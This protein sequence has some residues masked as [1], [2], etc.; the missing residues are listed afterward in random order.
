MPTI[1]GVPYTGI[2]NINLKGV[3]S[4]KGS[5]LRFERTSSSN[6]FDS[7]SAGLYVNSSGQLIF[8]YNGTSTTLGATGVSGSI[9]S[10]DAIFQGDQ[11]LD[12]G[13]LSTLTIDRSTGNNNVLTLTNSG[14]GSGNVLQITN[15][16]SGKDINGTSNTWSVT[17]AGVAVFESATLSGA[18]G[19][20]KFTIT[21]G[22]AVLS[23]GSLTMTDADNAATLSITNNTAT[24][25]SVFVFAGSGVFTGSTT[26]SFMT[27]TPS[28]LTTG[29]AVYLPVAG[30]TTGKAVHIVGNA[31]TTGN[32]L[33]ISSSATAITGTGRML[34]LEH[35]GTTGTSATLAEITSAATD[36]TIIFKA[37]AS[38]A[39]AAGVIAKLSGSSMTTGTALQINNL[40]ALTTGIGVHIAS[41]A[42]AI[43]GAGR[44]LYVNHTGAT[45]TSA[46]L[47][48]I[49]SAANDETVIFKVT[50]SAALA[51]GKVMFLSAAAL[52]TGTVLDISGSTATTTGTLVNINDN[53]ADTGTRSLV[54]IKQDHASASGATPLTI[55]N[56]NA[57]KPLI[58]GTATAT[59]T[60][61]YKF[62]TVNGVTIWIGAGTT[63]NGNLTGTAGDICLNGGSNKPEYCTG[64]TNW[65]ALV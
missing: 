28:G 36:E 47:A 42:T 20:D 23:D 64:T 6:P 11:T 33:H 34:Y 22:D 24:T 9:P 48:E 13:G 46:T 10:L 21:A 54:T 49:A 55:L 5:A 59:S 2:R 38:A 43:T 57:T 44:M 65:T 45:G 56:D 63:A 29:T 25:A 14:A 32:L 41:A 26:S 51:A 31:L 50:A 30:L 7:S 37:T 1:N 8:S 58:A 16:G 19:A 35:T 12:L 27:I 40:D 60:N 4:T 62:A 52:T 53:S 18:G 3:D 15:V 39:L 61:Y 17:K